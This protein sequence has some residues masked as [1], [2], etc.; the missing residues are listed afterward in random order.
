MKEKV[1]LIIVGLNFIGVGLYNLAQPVDGASIFEIVLAN[2]SSIN[3]IRANYG[4]MHLLLGLFLIHGAFKMH[5]QRT[6]L[7]VVA[8][9]TGGLVLGRITSLV[10]DGSPNEVVWAL[11]IVEA[12]GFLVASG[13][14][15][16][17]SIRGKNGA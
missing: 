5:I 3:E 6:A 4:G 8:L 16:L 11:F 15:F 7:L 10:V 12:V 13:L 14:Y 2:V 9:F 1:F 17:S